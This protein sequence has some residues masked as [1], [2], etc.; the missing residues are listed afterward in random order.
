MTDAVAGTP[1]EPSRPFAFR[2]AVQATLR[3][4]D[5]LGHVNNAVYLSW[6]ELART[7]YVLERRSLVDLAQVDFILASARLDWRSPVLMLEWVDVWCTP[8]RVGRRSWEL[9]YEG[10]SRRDG[11][12][13]LEATSVQ[14]QY[15]YATRKPAPVPE[16]F[17]RLL[18]EDLAAFPRRT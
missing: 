18:E 4:T 2:V 5:A 17:R 1:A 6:C 16:D 15:D 8:V 7:R 11:R 14:V 3:D 13:V 10:R 9:A 12:L